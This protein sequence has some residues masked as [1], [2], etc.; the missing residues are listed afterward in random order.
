MGSF[1][2]DGLAGEGSS[3]VHFQT[4]KE[5]CQAVEDCVNEAGIDLDNRLTRS[6]YGLTT[7]QIGSLPLGIQRKGL[8]HWIIRFMYADSLP[9]SIEH[10]FPGG[11]REFALE[12][13]QTYSAGGNMVFNTRIEAVQ[14]AQAF[15][16]G[17]EQKKIS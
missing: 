13:Q 9:P 12:W 14:A 15:L 1:S 10:L 8:K 2:Y 17:V 5:A 11:V 16:Q 4:L 3:A 7:Y 6:R